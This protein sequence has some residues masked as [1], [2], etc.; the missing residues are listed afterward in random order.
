MRNPI[1]DIGCTSWTQARWFAEDP[2]A[3][4][5]RKASADRPT[6]KP[7]WFSLNDQTQANAFFSQVFGRG[8]FKKFQG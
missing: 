1:A 6:S 5:R 3:R 7:L 4:A 8:K 2:W